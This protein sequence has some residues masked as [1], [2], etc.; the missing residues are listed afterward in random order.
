LTDNNESTRQ[1]KT[2][3]NYKIL[4]TFFDLKPFLFGMGHGAGCTGLGAW[5]MEH[6]AQGV[7]NEAR[8]KMLHSLLHFFQSNPLFIRKLN[9]FALFLHKNISTIDR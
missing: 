9:G 5:E 7:E 1:V 6:C 3:E 2:S 8:A 4:T